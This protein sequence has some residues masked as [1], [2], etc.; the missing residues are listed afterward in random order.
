MKSVVFAGNLGKDEREVYLTLAFSP[1]PRSK[2]TATLNYP[3]GCSMVMEMSCFFTVSY[4]H[5]KPWVAFE[6]VKSGQSDWEVEFYIDWTLMYSNLNSQMRIVLPYLQHSPFPKAPWVLYP[7]V[8]DPLLLSHS[9]YIFSE[10][11][12]SHAEHLSFYHDALA[13]ANGHVFGSP[14]TV[15]LLTNSSISLYL[16]HVASKVGLVTGTISLGSN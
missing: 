2:H 14:C 16:R 4:S 3:M 10:L 12:L 11:S 6:H 8:P 13:P 5:Y 9:S 15:R 1:P 7:R